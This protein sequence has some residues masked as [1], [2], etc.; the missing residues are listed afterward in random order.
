VC[1]TDI[2]RFTNGNQNAVIQEAIRRYPGVSHRLD[3][4]SPDED[5]RYQAP[6]GQ[7]YTIR[8]GVSRYHIGSMWSVADTSYLQ[9]AVGMT[10][11]LTNR[12]ESLYPSPLEFRPERFLENP[13]LLKYQFSFGKGTRICLGVRLMHQ[14]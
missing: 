2:E 10:P 3:R 9:T 12:N 4:V 11:P 7:V 6:N 14:I 5:L 13:R 8:A 1:R